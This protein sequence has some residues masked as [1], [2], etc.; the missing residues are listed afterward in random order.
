MEFQKTK[1]MEFQN[2][3]WNSF[4]TFIFFGKVSFMFIIFRNLGG[5]TSNLLLEMHTNAITIL[6]YNLG[7]K[8]EGKERKEKKRRSVFFLFFFLYY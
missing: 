6:L 2:K 3:I 8:I 4:L 7:T 5:D 1:K